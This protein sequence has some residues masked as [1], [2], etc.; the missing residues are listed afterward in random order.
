MV[1]LDVNFAGL[2]LKNP[3]IIGFLS[4]LPTLKWFRV[5]NQYCLIKGSLNN[6]SHYL[7]AW[8]CLLWRCCNDFSSLKQKFYK[9]FWLN[10]CVISGY[11]SL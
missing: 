1:N 11:K 6:L 10:F 8:S 3:V 7:Q 9:Y 2:K 4:P 5:S